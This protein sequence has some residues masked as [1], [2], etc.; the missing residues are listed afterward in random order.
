MTG[1]LPA[2]AF[3]LGFQLAGTALVIGLGISL[4]GPV[5]GLLLL[6][7]WLFSGAPT[8]SAL[9]QTAQVLVAHLSLLFVPAAVGIIQHLDRLAIEGRILLTAVVLSTVLA[10]V[11]GALTFVL[12]V[13][14]TGAS[15]G[16]EELRQ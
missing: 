2:L 8:P 12:T 7:L 9:S 14:L 10:L 11:V 6:T 1:V 16:E 5:A 13:R 4:P 3:L 15:P